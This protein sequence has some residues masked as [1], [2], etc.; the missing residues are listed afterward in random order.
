MISCSLSLIT[1]KLYFYPGHVDNPLHASQK[2]SAHQDF[3]ILIC[4]SKSS[5][6]FGFSGR[7]RKVFLTIVLFLLRR[8][9]RGLVLGERG[10]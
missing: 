9:Y 4:C 3:E 1:V 6:I 8:P 2:L 7:E 10:H 5:L